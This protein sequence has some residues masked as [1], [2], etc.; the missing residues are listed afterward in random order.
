MEVKREVEECFQI[1][2][3]IHLLTPNL[4]IEEDYRKKNTITDCR[5][6]RIIVQHLP[7]IKDPMTKLHLISTVLVWKVRQI[8]RCV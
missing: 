1:V 4:K 8:G 6:V 7:L 3:D 2:G 5:T